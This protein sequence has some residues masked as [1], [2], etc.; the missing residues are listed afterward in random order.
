MLE[1]KL[2]KWQG[3]KVELS[4]IYKDEEGNPYCP[5]EAME[6][7]KAEILRQGFTFTETERTIE[8]PETGQFFWKLQTEKIVGTFNARATKY[9]LLEGD[10]VL[11]SGSYPTKANMVDH[12]EDFFIKQG[13]GYEMVYRLI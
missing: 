3:K 2:K 12:G 6:G 7:L 9:E 13:N 5:V 1:N 8:I 4:Y 11:V 10:K